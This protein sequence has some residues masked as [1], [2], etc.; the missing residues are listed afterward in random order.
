V[1]WVSYEPMLTSVNWRPWF[2]GEGRLG[3]DW[4]VVG[5]AS[6]PDWQSHMM[7]LAWLADT[8]DQCRAAGVPLFVKQD[9]G[10]RPGEQ[11]RIPN[12]LWIR[13][14]PKVIGASAFVGLPGTRPQ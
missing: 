3:L 14:F 13:E 12:E 1:R 10:R 8:V 5:G 11:G 6:G 4:I 9:S 2:R 7:D